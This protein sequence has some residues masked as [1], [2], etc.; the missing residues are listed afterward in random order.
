MER[1]EAGFEH[2]WRGSQCQDPN[3]CASCLVVLQHACSV[4]SVSPAISKTPPSSRSFPSSTVAPVGRVRESYSP[5]V[6][7]LSSTHAS[8]T[9]IALCKDF[10][11]SKTTKYVFF[12]LKHIDDS[13]RNWNSFSID[14]LYVSL[15][16]PCCLYGGFYQ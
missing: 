16:T 12:Y 1:G 6:L 5:C 14:Y 13:W 15:I 7:C 11:Q 8:N 4:V 2:S 9:L 3:H 10:N